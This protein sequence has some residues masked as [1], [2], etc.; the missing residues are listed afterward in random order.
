MTTLLKALAVLWM[1]WSVLA[2]LGWIGYTL[3]IIA[4][5][6]PDH[7]GSWDVIAWFVCAGTILANLR[8]R[9][10]RTRGDGG[11]QWEI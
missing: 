4:P 5:V 3:R 6:Q 1:I 9:N 2:P 11:S 10:T 7:G 8:R